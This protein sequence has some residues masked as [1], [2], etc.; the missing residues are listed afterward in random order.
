MKKENLGDLCEIIM[1]STPARNTSEYWGKGHPWVCIA[2]LKE[3]YLKYTKEEITQ[4]AVENARCRLIPKGT[5]LFSFKLSIG[6]MAFASRDL[7]TN[8]AI[9]ALIVKDKNKLS[10]D[11]LFYALKAA[12][13]VGSNQAA[14]GKTLNS[15][16]L[17]IIKIPL[18]D[19]LTDQARIATLLSRVEM[20]IV[21]R[22]DNRRLLDDFLKSTFLEMFGILHAD[23]KKWTPHKLSDLTE[24]VS[25]ATKGKKYKDEEMVEAPYM[26]VANVQDGHLNL[27]EIKT[28]FVSESEFK[29]Y[30]L[31]KGDILLT[32]GGDPDK[33]GRGSVWEEEIKNCIHQNHIFR[34][35]I[36]NTKLLNPYFLSALAGSV[37]GKTY[38]LKAA[39]Q[40]TGIASINST[41]LKNFPLF[42]PPIESQNQFAAI[43]EKVESLKNH[44]QQNLTE[45]ENLYGTLSQKAFKGELDLTR[46]P[47]NHKIFADLENDINE[48]VVPENISATLTTLNAFNQSATSLKAIERAARVSLFDLAQLESVKQA[49]AQLAAYR[50][51]LEQ[52]KNMSTIT[53]AMEQIESVMKPLNL[54]QFDS[55]SNSVEIARNMASAI[56]KIDMG[57]LEQHN[58]ALKHATAPFESMRSTM[59]KFESLNYDRIN[60]IAKK[61]ESALGHTTAI[62]KFD[63]G[64]SDQYSEALRKITDPFGD[65]RNAVERASTS[66]IYTQHL[67]A[68]N[69]LHSSIPDFSSWQKLAHD[70][71]AMYLEEYNEQSFHQEDVID[72]L[73]NEVKPISFDTLMQQLNELETVDFMGYETIKTILFDLLAEN[74]VMQ[75]FDEKQKIL[76]FSLVENGSEE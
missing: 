7:Y 42:L 14:M 68:A 40:T 5:L 67:E 50:S 1:G 20:L 43:V 71:L 21:T 57:W 62:P 45:L 30:L 27:N 66:S 6:K 41:Q 36:T 22:K 52:L 18:P 2:D 61:M 46:I 29:R 39:K 56:P 33:L 28:I 38:F 60:S 13:L 17:A 47:L 31:K 34:V 48:V 11:Y 65:M 69:R 59:A 58:D 12:R 26:R 64:L 75:V 8:E 16:S 53:S 9:A 37:Y 54:S 4:T 15:K 51:P 23:Y 24:I 70:P 72:I 32:E 44:Y 25:G 3:K 35:R 73:S 74:L 55:I 49:A 19:N 63:N 10:S 76:L